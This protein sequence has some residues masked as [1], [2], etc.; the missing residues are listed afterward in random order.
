MNNY[1]FA[2]MKRIFH[3]KAFLAMSGIYAGIF[4]LMMFVFFNPTF[5]ADAY[6]AK[7]K[8][9]LNFFPLFIGLASFLSIYYDD[10]K[11]KAMQIAIGYGIPRYK[12]VL[13]KFIESILLLSVIAFC[14]GVLALIMPLI[15]GLSINETQT[16]ELTFTVFAEM[17]R[18]VGYISIS[19]IPVFYTQN[20]VSGTICNVLLSSRTV[21]ILLTMILGQGFIVNTFGDLSKY[22]FTTQLYAARSTIVQTGNPGFALVLT[23]AVY[24]LLPVL[25]SAF[26]FNKKELEF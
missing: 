15:L 10:F 25:L 12:V 14:V 23:V 24:V 3:K 2:D 7:T 11:S 19:A 17:L 21:F 22:L 13:A 4:L 20:A 9:F 26:C 1:I 16:A 18:A 5:T 8:T 6:V